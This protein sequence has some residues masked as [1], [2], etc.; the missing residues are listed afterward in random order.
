MVT[1]RMNQQSATGFGFL[2]LFRAFTIV[3]A[4]TDTFSGCMFSAVSFLAVGLASGVLLGGT[5]D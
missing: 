2:R 5:D 4:L 1:I 3:I